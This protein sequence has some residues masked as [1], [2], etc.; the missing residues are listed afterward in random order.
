MTDYPEH[1]SA[2]YT[3]GIEDYKLTFTAKNGNFSELCC[4]YDYNT[5]FN[6][7]YLGISSILYWECVV[8]YYLETDMDAPVYSNSDVQ[9]AA[10]AAHALQE[11]IDF[12]S[13]NYLIGYK[14]G[15]RQE[16]DTWSVVKKRLIINGYNGG[17][18]NQSRVTSVYKE[19]AD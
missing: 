9:R 17:R 16:P 11:M 18:I 8:L 7:I 19:G 15:N 13:M 2:T 3:F 12:D 4:T 6:E 1:I 10:Q 5:D 14:N